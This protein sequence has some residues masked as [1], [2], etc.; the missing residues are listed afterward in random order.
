MRKFLA[1]FTNLTVVELKDNLNAR[2]GGTLYKKFMAARNS[3]PEDCRTTTLAFH[4]TV[5][6]NIDSICTN[7]YDPARRRGQAYGVG[8]YFATTPN[9]PMGYC[10]G[11]GKMLLNELLLG[12]ANEHHTKHGD[13]IVMKKPEH[14]LPRFV[15]TFK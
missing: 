13:I 1:K 2:S 11:G 4:G 6:T 8:E 14:D 3:L 9:I 7:G 15:V 5:T 10:H 12:R